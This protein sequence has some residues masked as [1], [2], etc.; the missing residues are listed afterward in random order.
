MTY[1]DRTPRKSQKSDPVGEVGILFT[2]DLVVADL[3][4]SNLN[5]TFELGVRHALKPRSTIVIAEE[6]FRDPFDID[7]IVI[8]RYVHLGSDIGFDETMRM[9]QDLQI[10]AYALKNSQAV[11]SPVYTVLAGLKQ[12]TLNAE[13]R[14][15]STAMLTQTKGADAETYAALFEIALK[16]S[17]PR[18]LVAPCNRRRDRILSGALIQSDGIYPTDTA[19]WARTIP[20][21]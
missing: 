20:L 15:P 11:D 10:L 9:R 14:M 5:A 1:H 2:A 8:R 16:G 18:R 4:T 6:Q 13:P 12:P 3:S 7:H 21:S 19:P 17:S